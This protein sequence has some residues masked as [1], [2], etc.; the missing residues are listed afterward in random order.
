MILFVLLMDKSNTCLYHKIY[1]WKKEVNE[2]LCL[3]GV[4]GVDA[5]DLSLKFGRSY[6]LLS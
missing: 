5:K 1:A 4:Q 2:K 6:M 3:R